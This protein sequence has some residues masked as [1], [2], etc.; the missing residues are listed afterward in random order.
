MNAFKFEKNNL[1]LSTYQRKQRINEDSGNSM[2]ACPFCFK[3]V[4]CKQHSIDGMYIYI[5]DFYNCEL[6]TGHAFIY[7]NNGGI[8]TRDDLSG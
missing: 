6:K 1:P 2:H 7:N 3:L 8:Y 4:M 5:S